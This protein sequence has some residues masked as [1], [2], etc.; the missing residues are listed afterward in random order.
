MN[1]TIIA[2]VLAVVGFGAIGG[3]VLLNKEKDVQPATTN[4][5]SSTGT[6]GEDNTS[7]SSNN[8][9]GDGGSSGD[10]QSGEVSMDIADFAFTKS[11]LTIKKG[12]KVTWT[13]KDSAKH[14]VTPDTE[15]PGFVGSGKLLAKGESYSYTFTTPG[16]YSYNCSPHPYMKGTIEVVE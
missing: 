3:V 13:N 10:V 8:T 16:K 9:V 14:D 6:S 15:D 11:D 4:N 1:K 5:Q 7:G 12:T 2:I